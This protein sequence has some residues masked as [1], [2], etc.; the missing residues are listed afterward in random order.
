MEDLRE[1]PVDMSAR[2]AAWRRFTRGRRLATIDVRDLII[3]N[4]S[5]YKRENSFLVGSSTRTPAVLTKLQPYF[6]EERH[7]GVLEMDA[8]TPSAVIAHA[9]DR[10][11]CDNEVIAGLQADRPFRRGIFPT[12]GLRMGEASFEAASFG[13]DPISTPAIHTISQDAQRW[14]R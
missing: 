1:I 5:P 11:D 3:R 12:G 8:T 4:A 10:I 14:R 13:P 6:E 9:P 7:R 2:T